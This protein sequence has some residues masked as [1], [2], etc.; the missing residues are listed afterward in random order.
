[1]PNQPRSSIIGFRDTGDLRE[2]L[3]RIA[4]DRG[5]KLSDIVRRACEEYVRRYPLDEDD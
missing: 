3:E 1:M 5:E 4:A 2:A